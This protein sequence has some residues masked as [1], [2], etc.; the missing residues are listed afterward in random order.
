MTLLEKAG[1]AFCLY[2]VWELA[3]IPIAE[4]GDEPLAVPLSLYQAL[5][6]NRRVGGGS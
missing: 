1:L 6:F 5:V 4:S 2:C 3:S